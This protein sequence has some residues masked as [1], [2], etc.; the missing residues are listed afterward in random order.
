MAS[1]HQTSSRLDTWYLYPYPYPYL[2]NLY[3]FAGEGYCV[4][5]AIQNDSFQS[6]VNSAPPAIGISP[7]CRYNCRLIY[8]LPGRDILTLQR[9]YLCC[10]SAMLK[11]STMSCRTGIAKMGCTSSSQKISFTTWLSH[12]LVIGSF[13]SDTRIM[14]FLPQAIHCLFDT[15]VGM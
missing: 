5:P 12:R 11:K 6:R 9:T 14:M 1:F 2:S 7:S 10:H 4:Q 13:S 15:L 8:F 3:L